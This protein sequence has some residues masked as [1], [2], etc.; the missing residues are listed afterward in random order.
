MAYGAGRK[1]HGLR[2]VPRRHAAVRPNDLGL[3]AEQYDVREQCLI[4]NF[5]QVLSHLAVVKTALLLSG[6]AR[7]HRRSKAGR[8]GK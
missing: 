6:T 7:G 5:P 3:L 4:G 1:M 2:A 8:G